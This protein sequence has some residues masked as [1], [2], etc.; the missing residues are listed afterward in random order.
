MTVLEAFHLAAFMSACLLQVISLPMM[1]HS[2]MI[3]QFGSPPQINNFSS[4]TPPVAYPTFFGYFAEEQTVF[5]PSLSITSIV[6]AASLYPVTKTCNVFIEGEV[7]VEMVVVAISDLTLQSQLPHFPW[8]PICFPLAS[9][10][11]EP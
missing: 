5:L 8:A 1:Q 2:L 10:L 7:V 6:S 3:S 11:V 9:T 4:I